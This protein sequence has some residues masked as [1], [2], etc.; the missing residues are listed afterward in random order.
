MQ[1]STQNSSEHQSV[2]LFENDVLER[3]SHVHPVTP[4][5]FW[6]PIAGWLLWRSV[7][8][9]GFGFQAILAMAAAGIFTWTLARGFL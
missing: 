7:T 2:R 8:V 9:H 5:L 6:S 4:L 1:P 3:L